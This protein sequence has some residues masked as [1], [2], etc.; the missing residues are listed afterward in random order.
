MW[1]NDAIIFFLK[2]GDSNRESSQASY[3]LDHHFLKV[4]TMKRDSSS[5]DTMENKGNANWS[6]FL[7]LN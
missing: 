3:P 4:C 1:I 2:P 7:G 5:F 6:L